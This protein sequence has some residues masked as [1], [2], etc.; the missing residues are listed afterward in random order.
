[1]FSLK[2]DLIVQIPPTQIP[3]EIAEP[4]VERVMNAPAEHLFKVSDVFDY[5]YEAAPH[6]FESVVCEECGEMVTARN[7]GVQ[8]GRMLCIPCA[9]L[10]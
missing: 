7:A 3:A 9:G 4:L 5:E 2:G 6:T 1:M 8:G 10:G